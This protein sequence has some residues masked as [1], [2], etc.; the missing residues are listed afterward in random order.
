MSTATAKIKPQTKLRKKRVSIRLN[1]DIHQQAE[2]LARA[3]KRSFLQF[4][5]LALERYLQ[6]IQHENS[7]LDQQVVA[8]YLQIGAIY[9][10]FTPYGAEAAAEKLSELLKRRPT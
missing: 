4:V 3:D 10:I 8:K 2:Q 5:E 1:P 9:P 6:A 7:T